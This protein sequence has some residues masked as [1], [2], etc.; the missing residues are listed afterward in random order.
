MGVSQS[1]QH[2]PLTA[3]TWQRLLAGVNCH[4]CQHLTPPPSPSLPFLC[5][6]RLLPCQSPLRATS[7]QYSSFF[8]LYLRLD[9]VE[10]ARRNVWKEPAAASV[11]GLS[12]SPRT[13]SLLQYTFYLLQTLLSSQPT[14]IALFSWDDLLSYSLVSSGLEALIMSSFPQILHCTSLFQPM[15]KDSI[16]TCFILQHIRVS[17]ITVPL[18]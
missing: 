18:H 4:L 14:S 5:V 15:G 12:P 8:L 3:K 2:R 9:P 7:I 1:A 10:G 11:Y 17:R 16:S 6:S 13:P